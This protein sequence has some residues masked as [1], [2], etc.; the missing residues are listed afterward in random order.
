VNPNLARLQPYP[1]EK[2]R[3][4]YANITPSRPYAPINL[5]IGEPKH[6]T[7]EFIRRALTENLGGLASYPLTAGTPALREAAAGSDCRLADATLWKRIR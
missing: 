3:A 1:F 2:L 7:P 6:P 4:L 5:S